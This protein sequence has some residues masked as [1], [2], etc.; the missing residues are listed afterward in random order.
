MN[1]TV[2]EKEIVAVCL[3]LSQLGTL[4]Y[5]TVV[6]VLTGLTNCSVPDFVKLFDFLL[7]QAKVKALNADT[8]EGNA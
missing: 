7:Q 4:P 6:D 1:L 3:C 8:Q 2:A 5:E